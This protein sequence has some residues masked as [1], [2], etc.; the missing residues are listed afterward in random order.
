MALRYV[1]GFDL[2]RLNLTLTLTENVGSPATVT[3]SSGTY[4]HETMAS[5]S[6]VSGYTAFS[7]AL[8]TAL[9]AASPNTRTYTVTYSTSTGKYT[10][11]VSAG[12]FSLT[13]STHSTAGTNFRNMLGFSGDTSLGSSDTSDYKCYYVIHSGSGGK[14]EASDDYEPEGYVTGAVSDSGISYGTASTLAPTHNDW[15]QVAE[16]KAATFSRSAAT[17]TPWTYEHFFKHVRADLPFLVVDDAGTAAH[18]LRAEAAHWKPVRM[19]A[20]YDGA[21]TIPFSTYIHRS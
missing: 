5:Y 14:T 11:G 18:F 13:F 15:Q 3:M 10:I 12:T 6:A 4:A 8:K 20:D 1:A 19:F 2:A 17:A 21:W 7:A 16:T 9:D